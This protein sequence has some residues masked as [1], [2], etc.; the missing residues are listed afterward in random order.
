MKVIN[1]TS[2]LRPVNTFISHSNEFLV[3][4]NVIIF[5]R[6]LICN[7]WTS[8]TQKFPSVIPSK[9]SKSVSPMILRCTGKISHGP[10]FAKMISSSSDTSR[11][12]FCAF[13]WAPLAVTSMPREHNQSFAFLMAPPY[14]LERC[15]GPTQL[16]W[17]GSIENEAVIRKPA[18]RS[19]NDGQQIN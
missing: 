7:S 19:Q 5:I 3:N 10:Y 8:H 4:D 1:T 16:T 13:E 15:V 9:G 12:P 17:A 14:S 2:F 18:L 11:E 6:I